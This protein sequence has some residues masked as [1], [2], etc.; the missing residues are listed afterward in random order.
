MSSALEQ[1]ALPQ[2][3]RA[4]TATA[5]GHSVGNSMLIGMSRAGLNPRF[6]ICGVCLTA[7]PRPHSATKITKANAIW[8]KPASAKLQELECDTA[9]NNIQWQLVRRNSS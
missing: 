2:A 4:S 1:R 6:D 7:R 3:A 9:F 5:T 8:R